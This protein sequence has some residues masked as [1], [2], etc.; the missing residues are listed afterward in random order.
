MAAIVS[1]RRR[2]AGLT[3]GLLICITH[4]YGRDSTRPAAAQEGQRRAADPGHAGGPA[5]ARLRHR[6]PDRAA[7]EGHRAFPRGVALSAA[8]PARPQGLDPRAL[9]G[10]G[11]AAAAA[12]LPADAGRPEGP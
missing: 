8:V 6:P 12:V 11:G 1:P 4:T 7:L 5:P 10:E 2:A 3:H 9:A